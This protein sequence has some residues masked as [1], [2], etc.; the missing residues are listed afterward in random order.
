[1]A[2]FCDWKLLQHRY[3]RFCRQVSHGTIEKDVY[4]IPRIMF[5][6][7]RTAK[8]LVV[9]VGPHDFLWTTFAAA[10]VILAISKYC[11]ILWRKHQPQWEKCFTNCLYFSQYLI[12]Y[13]IILYASG[14]GLY[15]RPTV[16]SAP[17][18]ARYQQSTLK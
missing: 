3:Y 18:A 7:V 14:A 16:I 5:L 11:P 1:V 13:M 2:L 4:I 6:T 17:F 15:C 12:S 9:D 10:S 8:S